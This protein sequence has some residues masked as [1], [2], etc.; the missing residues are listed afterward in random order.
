M[1]ALSV[2][3]LFGLPGCAGP[4]AAD[5]DA[6]QQDKAII[7][8]RCDLPPAAGELECS[9]KDVER[10]SCQVDCM[11]IAECQ[12]LDGTAVVDGGE[13]LEVYSACLEDC[14]GSQ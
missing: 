8:S 6:V 4:C 10:R 2:L 13:Q 9:E 1:S 3:F 5:C 11:A 14:P 12:I 7:V